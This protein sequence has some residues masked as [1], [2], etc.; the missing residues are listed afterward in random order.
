MHEY[1]YHD[2][3]RIIGGVEIHPWDT[4]IK[5][6]TIYA[7]FVRE[8]D[9]FFCLN[10]AKYDVSDGA[11][12]FTN[13]EDSVFGFGGIQNGHD[14]IMKAI[15]NGASIII[16]DDINY[17]EERQ[18]VG[19]ILVKD[20]LLALSKF[21]SFHITSNKTK[22][23]AVTGSTGKT[24]TCHALVETL[25]SFLTVKTIHRIR[26]SILA[27]C[28]EIM[29]DISR[30]ADC[31]VLEMQLDKSGQIDRFCQLLSPDIAIIT[32]INL[33][34]Y[35]RF[36]S[37]DSVLNEKL[38]VYRHLKENGVLLINDDNE[39]LH[40][41]YLTQKDQ[42]IQRMGKRIYCEYTYDDPLAK[43]SQLPLT[44]SATI[45]DK[46]IQNITLNTPGIGSVVA[47]TTCFA[48]ANLLSLP[49]AEVQ[50]VVSHI[51]SPI[52]R[53]S[54]FIGK[55]SSRIIV[56]SYNA[57]YAS[58]IQ[59][60]N[61]VASAPQKRKILILGSMLELAD[62]TEAVHREL[63]QYINGLNTDLSL[64]TLGE[65]ALYIAAEITKIQPSQIY[66][67]FTYEDIV[68][69]IDNI[70]L[71]ADTVVFI[72]GSGAMRLELIV[73]YLLAEQLF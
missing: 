69:A 11:L 2:L 18:G 14:Q 46:P 28:L 63:G 60:I 27:I 49:I 70:K 50:Q 67:T 53:F 39:Y 20:C 5:S 72:K 40:N 16:I 17:F 7:D 22:V 42:R 29:Q 24:T 59:G 26:N 41:W 61:Y 33:A 21:I 52:G 71:D 48:V 68:Y 58:M 25:S 38:G 9:L 1:T 55:N 12:G 15:A 23:I 3:V 43:N 19:F 8:G 66:T 10:S 32:N 56:D 44:Y 64:I 6:G 62:Q 30:Q 37:I 51:K 35:S 36:Y 57:S 4:V 13:N 65:A 34:H 31:I 47:A 73:P 45:L 54:C